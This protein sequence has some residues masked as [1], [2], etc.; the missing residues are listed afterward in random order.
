MDS[1]MDKVFAVVDLETTGV[2]QKDGDR[3]I[4]FGCALIKK[5]QVVKTYSF[6]INPGRPIPK[7]VQQL[8]HI[9]NQDVANQ[10]SF[11]YYAPKIQEI[12]KNTIFVAHNVNFDFPFLNAELI[13]N[14]FPALNNQAIDTVELA[15]IAFP[16]LPSY[17]LRDLTNKLEIKHLHPHH[18]DSDAYG[19]AILLL[20]IIDR[21]EKLPQATLNTLAGMSQQLLRDSSLIIR[22]IAKDARTHKRPLDKNLVQVGHLIL[23][24]QQRQIKTGQTE[25]HFPIA[26]AAKREMFKGKISYRKAQV[27]LIDHL[28]QFLMQDDLRAILVE[29]PNGTGKTFSYLFAYAYQLSSGRKLVIAVPTQILQE[30]IAHNEIKQLL[31]VTGLNLKS[32]IVKSPSH[33]LDLDGFYSCLSATNNQTTLILKMQILVWLTET[34]TGDLDELQLTSY[35]LPLFVQLQHPGDAR[36]GSRFANYDFWNLARK[37]QEDADILIT[38][39]A[40]LANHYT[41]SIW[42]QKPYL[43]I[44]EAHRFT[45]SVLIS[46][47]NS[48]AFESL[49]G[50]LSHLRN[51]LYYNEDNLEDALGGDSHFSFLLEQ[52]NPYLLATIRQINHLQKFLASHSKQA[53][54]KQQLSNG[55]LKISFQASKLFAPKAEFQRQLKSL[56]NRIETIRQQIQDL[57][58]QLYQVQDTF[59]TATAGILSELEKQLD[60]FDYYSEKCYALDYLLN[61]PKNLK[62]AGFIL[63]LSDPNDPL[64]ANLEWISVDPSPLLKA[65]YARFDHISFISASL[66]RKHDFSY[67]I[68]NLALT[69]LHPS[70]YLGKESFNLKQH[71]QVLSLDDAKLEA[72]NPDYCRLVGEIISQNCQSKNHI[73]ALFT[74]LEVIKKIYFQLLN[75]PRMQDFELLAQGQTGS[76]PKI[77]KRFVLAK[78]AII[79]GAYSFWEGIDFHHCSI[80]LVIAGKLPF[81]VPDEASN[82]LRANSL[83]EKGIDVFH[84]DT[85]PQTL[86]RFRQGM[87]RLIRNEND[88]GQFLILDPRIWQR[89][90]G[91]YFLEAIPVKVERIK[92]KDLK[93][94]LSNFEHHV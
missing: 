73:L 82:K 25:K 65:I 9:S 54:A 44:D 4:Q 23:R 76:N 89:D 39:H 66:A 77:A 30:Q 29:A 21:L 93:E 37:R 33:Y 1:F 2:R 8:T 42:G 81:P 84:D 46:R 22:T 87:G 24:R 7:M 53:L 57:L 10:K 52:L 49:W 38:N 11:K 94:K 50:L 31:A 6:M 79:L 64:S 32:E 43:V 41:D 80:D 83:A 13:A 90:Y 74:N 85:L 40:Y 70:F 20:K 92:I 60:R 56:E 15:K 63:I 17:R 67:A 75:N 3:I 47:Q 36:V 48:L 72:S 86:I 55:K 12:L 78:K 19:T 35:N 51:L 18:A 61:R 91:K 69:D 59:L 34:K 45:T 68:R 88:Y 14:G 58:T 71:L 5:C 27:D 28:H 26:S 16:Q 62:T